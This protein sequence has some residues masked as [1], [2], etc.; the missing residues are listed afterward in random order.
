MH[1]KILYISKAAYNIFYFRIYIQR[2]LAFYLIEFLFNK[3]I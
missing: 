2:Q 1:I 3:K